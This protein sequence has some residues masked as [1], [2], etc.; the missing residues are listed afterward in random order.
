[1]HICQ[2]SFTRQKFLGCQNIFS[3][4]SNQFLFTTRRRLLN[5]VVIC[6][7]LRCLNE[8]LNCRLNN[9]FTFSSGYDLELQRHWRKCNSWLRVLWNSCD[10]MRPSSSSPFPLISTEL[11]VSRKRVLVN[12]NKTWYTYENFV[13]AFFCLMKGKYLPEKFEIR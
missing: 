4:F 11:N 10:S 9:H 13:F 3:Y 8:S 7:L 2:V 6:A 5:F 12:S 1:M